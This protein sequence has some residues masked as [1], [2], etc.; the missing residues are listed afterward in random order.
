MDVREAT[1]EDLSAIFLR[2]Y[3][4]KKMC[5]IPN[6]L[7]LSEYLLGSYAYTGRVDGKIVCIAGVKDIGNGI[8][9]AWALMGEDFDKHWIAVY[10]EI[11]RHLPKLIALK[12]Y[13]RLQVLV[14]CDFPKAKSFIQSFGF[15]NETPNGMKNYGTK[16]ESYFLYARYINA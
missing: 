8:G 9:E 3:D 12:G 13:K 6:P 11:K 15:V 2:E 4:R 10:R 1:T 16:G 5:E 14:A 7:E